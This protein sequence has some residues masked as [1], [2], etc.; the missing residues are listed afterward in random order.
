MG[1]KINIAELLKD[2]PQG[3]ELDCTMYEN[4]YF[5]KTYNEEDCLYPIGCYIIG[6]NNRNSVNF[7]KYGG[8]NFHSNAKCIIFPKGKNYLGGILFHPVSLRM[9]IFLFV[10]SAFS[11]ILIYKDSEK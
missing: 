11:W 5:D 8:F 1:N 7:T 2:C 10:K 4:V 6:D 9:E 3:M